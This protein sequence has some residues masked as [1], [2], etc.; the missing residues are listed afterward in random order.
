[1]MNRGV[2][3]V[4][5][6]IFLSYSWKDVNYVNIIDSSFKAKG[7]NLI[8]DERNVHYKQSLQEFMKQVKYTDYVLVIISENYLKSVNCMYEALETMKDDNYRERILP[9]I[10]DQTD[11]FNLMGKASYIEFWQNEFSTIKSKLATLELE[12]SGKIANDLKRIRE[13]SLNIGEFL[14]VISDMNCLS[15][16]KHTSDNF[17]QIITYISEKMDTIPID[18]EYFLVELSH[19]K[20]IELSYHPDYPRN[21]YKYKVVDYK[22]EKATQGLILILDLKRVET[23]ES[24]VFSIT[25]IQEIEMNDF[26]NRD[27]AK[28]YLKC[29]S[30]REYYSFVELSE[31]KQQGMD[32][33]SNELRE[34][35]QKITYLYRIIIIK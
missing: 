22:I 17:Q 11:I 6:N 34:L 28:Y 14:D 33:D 19:S 32:V 20:Y 35:S 29:L 16:A 31:Y 2:I 30:R 21:E 26:S 25:D 24:I 8:R 1:M 9:I 18:L 4:N 27:F 5:K 13:I 3:G 12:N 7:I 15:L 10:L 23:G